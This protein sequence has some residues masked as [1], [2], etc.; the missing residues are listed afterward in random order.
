MSNFRTGGEGV[1][2][3]DL[4]AV[5]RGSASCRGSEG[6]D[7]EAITRPDGTSACAV[8]WMSAG[9][10]IRYRVNALN[11]AAYNITVRYSYPALGTPIVPANVRSFRLQLDALPTYGTFSLPPSSAGYGT[12]M[13]QN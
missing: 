8:G 9:E 3:H 2:Y 13:W 12:W 10:W 1:A 7:M 4:D 5:N 11:T 6:V